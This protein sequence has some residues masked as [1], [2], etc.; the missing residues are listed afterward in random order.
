MYLKCNIISVCCHTSVLKA[1]TNES[2]CFMCKMNRKG[3]S[4]HQNEWA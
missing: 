2:T 4:E 3:V 1:A